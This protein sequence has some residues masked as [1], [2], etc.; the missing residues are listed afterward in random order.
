MRRSFQYHL[1]VRTRSDISGSQRMAK[2]PGSAPENRPFRIADALRTARRGLPRALLS[3]SAKA[4][5][6]GNGSPL[7][8]CGQLRMA[9]HICSILAG[10]GITVRGVLRRKTLASWCEYAITLICALQSIYRTR[11]SEE[12][13][14]SHLC[15]GRRSRISSPRRSSMSWPEVRSGLSHAGSSSRWFV[16]N[17]QDRS[18]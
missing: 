8:A 15:G 13:R 11:Y 9:F 5:R 16:R 14:R 4:G 7:S 10:A 1:G 6:A 12:P 18:A 3:K 17:G 2:I